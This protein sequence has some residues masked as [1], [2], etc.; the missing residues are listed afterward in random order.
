VLY[1]KSVINLKFICLLR[2]G[3]FKL[4]NKLCILVIEGVFIVLVQSLSKNPERT[5]LSGDKC[6]GLVDLAGFFRMEVLSGFTNI[7]S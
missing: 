3:S 6:V 4:S 7:S 5:L 1:A 2:N